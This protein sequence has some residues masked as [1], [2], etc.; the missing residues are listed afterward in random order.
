MHTLVDLVANCSNPGGRSGIIGPSHG[1]VAYIAKHIDA[2]SVDE[3]QFKEVYEQRVARP[4][5]LMMKIIDD[6]VAA[7]EIKQDQARLQDRDD[8]VG[9]TVRAHQLCLHIGRFFDVDKIY[10]EYKKSELRASA[11]SGLRRSMDLKKAI[12]VTACP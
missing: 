11:P 4:C 2:D 10:R 3:D 12:R 9:H 8:Y 5:Q 6:L 1:V 7:D